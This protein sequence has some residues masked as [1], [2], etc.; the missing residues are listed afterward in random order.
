[1][2]EIVIH[3]IYCARKSLEVWM[4]FTHSE[5][6]TICTYFLHT[7]KFQTK[8]IS[9][10]YF[11]TSVTV[12]TLKLVAPILLEISD[13]E[14]D[15]STDCITNLKKKLQRFSSKKFNIYF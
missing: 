4:L 12:S 5:Y 15:K 13:Q 3:N 10:T 6:L 1:M 8:P 7:I 9:L 14:C 11:H 2:T